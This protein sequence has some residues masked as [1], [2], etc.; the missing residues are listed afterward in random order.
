MFV[1]VHEEPFPVPH[2]YSILE[3]ISDASAAQRGFRCCPTARA[4]KYRE[5]N[6]IIIMKIITLSSR[7]NMKTRNFL[8]EENSVW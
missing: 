1:T 7:Q 2:Y 3:V 4:I 8:K 6:Y 5:T